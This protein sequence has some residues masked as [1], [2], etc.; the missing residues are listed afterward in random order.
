M[1]LEIYEKPYELMILNQISKMSKN[2]NQ[3]NPDERK[4][5]QG[6]ATA[7]ISNRLRLK[8]LDY[9]RER[10]ASEIDEFGEVLVLVARSVLDSIESY[11]W[12]PQVKPIFLINYFQ[13][14]H[15]C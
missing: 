13:I 11:S 12:R 8:S 9:N 15:H 5:A 3:Y 1:Y 6:I 10:Y 2:K 7:F 4:L 14:L